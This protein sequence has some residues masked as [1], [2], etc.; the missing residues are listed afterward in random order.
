MEPSVRLLP[1]GSKLAWNLTVN[2]FDRCHVTI[3][4]ND[5]NLRW[6]SEVDG[7]ATI[8]PAVPLPRGTRPES[9]IVRHSTRLA[10][11]NGIR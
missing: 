2:L 10:I 6:E 8:R 7:F 1:P 11:S 4:E 9:A 5:P 3:D